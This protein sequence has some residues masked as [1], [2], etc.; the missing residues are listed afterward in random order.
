MRLVEHK[1]DMSQKGFTL[2][3]LIIFVGIIGILVSVWPTSY[4][5]YAA[6]ARQAEAELAL[7]AIYRLKK[8]SY[9][10]YSAYASSFDA[11]GYKNSCSAWRSG[12]NVQNL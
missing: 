7:S 6:K 5:R 10:E 3:E 11:I 8:S 12:S 1:Q 4:D 9:S 2:I